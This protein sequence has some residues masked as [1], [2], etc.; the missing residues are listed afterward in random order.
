MP[1]PRLRPARSSLSSSLS[2]S[3]I[4]LLVVASACAPPAPGGK[5]P[6][7]GGGGQA[8][9]A[10]NPGGGGGGSGGGIGPGGGGG[11]A[12]PGGSGGGAGPGGSGGGVGP[13]G[14]GGQP[15]GD[16][17][18]PGD[19]AA[20]MA[21]RDG[22]G[23]RAPDGGAA[24]APGSDGP[25]LPPPPTYPPHILPVIFLDVPGKVAEPERPNS[26]LHEKVRGTMKVVEDHDGMHASAAAVK[27]R[28]ATLETT[29]AISKR[30]ESSFGFPQASF[31]VE[32]RDA[33]MNAVEASV[34]GLPPD[35]DW[36]LVS[37]WND[38]T[39]MRHALA[40]AIGREMGDWHP[41]TRFVEVYFNNDY[42][43]LYL[44]AEPPRRSKFR[45]NITKVADDTTSMGPEGIT[46]G[47]I[48]RREGGGKSEEPQRNFISSATA[49][50]GRIR[51]LFV[52]HYPRETVINPAQRDYLHKY[53]ASFEEA[54]KAGNWADPN[55][56]YRSWIDVRSW[57]RH[58]LIHEAAY[59]IDAF[60][61]SMYFAKERDAGG[62]RGKLSI[63]PVWDFN[64]AW[65][66]ADYRDGWKTDASIRNLGRYVGEC[67]DTQP[68]PSGCGT[69]EQ[70]M[71]PVWSMGAIPP[72]R[73]VN[74]MYLPFWWDRLLRDAS[75]LNDAKCDFQKNRAGAF[76]MQ[77]IDRNIDAWKA[78][79]RPLAVARHFRRWP[80]LRAKVWPNPCEDQFRVPGL[81]SPNCGPANLGA[82]EFF[83][84]EVRWFREW[85]RQRL[86]WMDRS[87][88]GT[89]SQ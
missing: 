32:I 38:K 43:G 3:L 28:P 13:G 77:Y 5:K 14:A 68:A 2:S 37:C 64:I 71:A 18:R 69:C 7:A 72:A 25:V 40:Y 44:L 21:G 12:N 39:C 85:V 42:R 26:L 16:A 51:T 57:G 87:L 20:P 6:P 83:D 11:G 73:C 78:Q 62:A 52:Y 8:G 79:L 36:A 9:G 58:Y 46:G 17:G 70:V 54:M 50:D 67:L 19:G 56:G 27:A 59:N 23:G 76:S 31:S 53:V 29:I 1:E 81:P 66:N 74:Y 35:E 48:F 45:T 89:C 65:G 34:A 33:T 30:G 75:F 10:P 82:Q 80:M 84:H 41:R 49:P 4:A 86:E 15:V 60:W 88:P 63:N 55:T 47:Y 22:G 61:K 24:G